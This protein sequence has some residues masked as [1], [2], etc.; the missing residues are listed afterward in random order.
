MAI[1]Y[2]NSPFAKELVEFNEQKGRGRGRKGPRPKSRP[3]PSRK[4]PLGLALFFGSLFLHLI[5]LGSPNQVVFDEVHVGKYTTAYCCTGKHFFDVH[6]PHAK[7]LLAGTMRLAG[8][9]GNFGFRRIGEPYTEETSP[10]ALRW[11]SALLGALIPFL[12]FALIRQLGGS[13]PAAF[14][15]GLALLLE[16]SLLVQTRVL[17]PDSI[18][19]SST[20][21]ALVLFLMA[22]RKDSRRRKWWLMLTGT[23]AG[24]AVGSKLSG[25]AVIGI[26]FVVLFK[27][28]VMK[29]NRS[30]FKFGAKSFA[31][32][33]FTATLVYVA[34][35]FVHFQLLDQPGV[36]DRFYRMKKSFVTDFIGYHQTTF[37]YSANLTKRHPGSSAWWQWPGMYQPIFYWSD[38]RRQI[39]FAPNP[40]VWLGT[41]Y[42]LF[43][44][45]G[46]W[47]LRRA[48]TLRVVS[49]RQGNLVW[50][51]VAG[52]FMTWL[53]FALLTR[54]QFLYNHLT[55]LIFAVA[56]VVLFLDHAE[57]IPSSRLNKQKRSFYYVIG[58]I[59]LGFVFLSPLTYGFTLGPTWGGALMNFLNFFR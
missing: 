34:G 33:L 37:R 52:F 5:W 48:T 54:T 30:T 36:G 16:N 28:F 11:F 10:W 50:I 56:S 6:P 58:A 22:L 43:M 32:V 51:P 8:Y 21:G 23:V 17:S 59:V 13:R 39:W 41:M 24:F 3:Q 25:L 38:Q 55:P 27:P 2:Q 4:R 46:V 14:L 44:L 53:P 49:S 45:F 26:I 31:W 7:L 1:E 57:W 15:G 20:L 12:V 9:E 35:W 42:F 47:G 19:I 29:R 18:L 40:V